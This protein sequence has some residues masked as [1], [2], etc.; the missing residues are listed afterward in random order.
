[1]PSIEEGEGLVAVVLGNEKVHAEAIVVT[2]G[3]WVS[4]LVE[5]LGID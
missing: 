5:P 2:A 4:G 3:P 1:M